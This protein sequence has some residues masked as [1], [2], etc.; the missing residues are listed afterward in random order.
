MKVVC[1]G[2]STKY[3][4]GDDKVAGKVF[5][6][7]CKK[8]SRVIIVR[9]EQAAAAAAR[10][11]PEWHAVHDG[12]QLGPLDSGE[13]MR[14]RAAGELTDDTYVWRD[15]FADWQ[16]LGSVEELRPLSLQMPAAGDPS[17]EV[18]VSGAKA[19]GDQSRASA[20]AL[21]G[22]AAARASAPS[23]AE[24]S[25][26]HGARNESSLLFTLDNLSRLAAPA[27][28]A[29]GAGAGAAS[30][31]RAGAAGEGSGLID[32]RRLAHSYAPVAPERG[33]ARAG[34]GGGAGTGIGSMA[35]LPVFPPA[36]FVEPAVLV[37]RAPKRDRRLL[38]G[39]VA[40][41]GMLAICA[42]LLLVVMV[43]RGGGE[44][45][46][47]EPTPAPRIATAE[48]PA[49]PR[50]ASPAVTEPPVA[51]RTA[52][53]EPPQPPARTGTPATT[54]VT[55]PTRVATGTPPARTGTGTPPARTGTGTPPART[56]TGT[57][58]PPAR[59]GTG[60]PPARTGTGTGTPPSTSP[61]PAKC[62]QVTC[63]V[64]GFDSDCCRALQ[65][66]NPL[67]GTRPVQPPTTSTQ[68]PEG[69]DRPAISEGLATISTKSCSGRAPAGS[70]V[71][72][73][74]KVSA[75]GAVTSVTIE[76]SP[77]EGLSACVTA[78][79]QKGRFKA[80]QRGGSFAYVWRF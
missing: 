68:L 70:L 21:F 60:T 20:G 24:A 5:K 46:A 53:T 65:A 8:C 57:G 43:T 58:T 41:V 11:E 42:V 55:P 1:E 2:C 38:V 15:G 19:A 9:G 17:H 12:K 56:G 13:L 72:A 36:T 71:K 45:V 80:T 54:E 10:T 31:V 48:R 67:L 35:D 66:A 32:I 74:V 7:R 33:V 27:P 14:R 47:S 59:T 49:T 78:Q 37:P 30:A 69:L 75:A 4:V 22:G 23:E 34:G 79:V 61:T 52:V 76:S 16:A 50:T 28:S 39:L 77:D 63:I 73:R 18:L 25:K 40:S 3:S 44:S 6:I 62:D 29:V 26:L 51:P 64:N